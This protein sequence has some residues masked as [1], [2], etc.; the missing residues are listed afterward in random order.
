[1]PASN[2]K[3]E[4]TQRMWDLAEKVAA[5]YVRGQMG[6]R[7]CW[8]A[9]EVVCPPR[10]ADEPEGYRCEQCDRHERDARCLP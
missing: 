8:V 7:Y 3:T 9:D 1:M 5:T 4:L 2:Y 10:K 6:F